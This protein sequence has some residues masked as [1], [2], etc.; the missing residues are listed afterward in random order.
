MTN[1]DRSLALTRIAAVFWAAV[2][3]AGVSVR[4]HPVS[5]SFFLTYR[6]DGPCFGEEALTNH[7]DDLARGREHSGFRIH[8]NNLTVTYLMRPRLTNTA[9]VSSVLDAL[10]NADPDFGLV[11]TASPGYLRFSE[12]ALGPVRLAAGVQW[13]TLL[14]NRSEISAVSRDSSLDYNDLYF[15]L[16]ADWRV[17]DGVRI[18]VRDDDR[19]VMDILTGHSRSVSSPYTNDASAFGYHVCLPLNARLDAGW[20]LGEQTLTLRRDEKTYT[21]NGNPEGYLNTNRNMASSLTAAALASRNL[22]RFPG[23]FGLYFYGACSYSRS[24]RVFY[25]ENNDRFSTEVSTVL[26]VPLYAGIVYNL[27]PGISWT[28][29]AGYVFRPEYSF[30]LVTNGISNAYR[31]ES[32]WDS[33]GAD[34]RN[35]PFLS[36]GLTGRSG[37]LEAGIFFSVRIDIREYS[38]AWDVSGRYA[39]GRVFNP[40]SF[41]NSVNY[42]DN[43]YLKWSHE[44]VELK[45]VLSAVPGTNSVLHLFS[46]FRLSVLF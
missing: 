15:D 37:P 42:D 30:L 32:G 11:R 2:L 13:Q 39:A 45:G 36:V 7:F 27:V 46:S 12:I 31:E 26:E 25:G 18:G 35:A 34:D 44:G 4:S 28:A 21:I 33:R 24:I 3:T 22:L 14:W 29:G 19:L 16:A 40:M 6:Q 9:S 1:S 20:F 43:V 23:G 38:A 8:F 10:T 17:T 5:G 41:V